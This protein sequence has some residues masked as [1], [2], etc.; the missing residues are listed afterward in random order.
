PTADVCEIAGEE[1]SFKI[2]EAI[3]VDGPT[4]DE[5]ASNAH[6]PVEPIAAVDQSIETA[7]SAR[8]VPLHDVEESVDIVE[9][10]AD[11]P[12]SENAP[13]ESIAMVA[14]EEPASESELVEAVTADEPTTE[15][16]ETVAVTEDLDTTDAVA[17][18]EPIAE[19]SETAV[20]VEERTVELAEAEEAVAEEAAADVA[21]DVVQAEPIAE[22]DGFVF[23]SE[24]AASEMGL[25]AADDDDVVL[26]DTA[27]EP[28]AETDEAV[29]EERAVDTA[30][31]VADVE[32]T[33]EIVEAAAYAEP[34]DEAD[35]VV[36]A[37][38]ER[39]A[40]VVEAVVEPVA[41]IDMAVAHEVPVI[42]ATEALAT[43]MPETVAADEL[44]VSPSR[45]DDSGERIAPVVVGTIEALDPAVATEMPDISVSAGQALNGAS[46]VE[47]FERVIETGADDATMPT[48][49]ADVDI[50]IH[51]TPRETASWNSPQSQIS[52][53]RTDSQV[54]LSVALDTSSAPVESELGQTQSGRDSAV[55]LDGDH[56]DPTFDDSPKDAASLPAEAQNGVS[57]D[58]AVP[59]PE[60]MAESSPQE[61][62]QQYSAFST[63]A[64]PE[65]FTHS[66]TPPQQTGAGGVRREIP[67]ASA[68]GS[69]VQK[70]PQSGRPKNVLMELNIETPSDGRQLL[71]LLISDDLDEVCEGFCAEHGM[72]DLLPGMKAL[73]RGK[74]ERR[75]ARRRERALQAAVAPGGRYAMQ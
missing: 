40:E 19:T 74:V 1:P 72:V 53:N 55:Y 29:A 60:H 17:E 58:Y 12:S 51:Q 49:P 47:S 7:E 70:V 44:V 35:Y 54:S 57:R 23:K 30:V 5:P 42:E 27:V 25:I 3:L 59:E 16:D 8:E 45:L 71:Q 14:T 24:V 67:R 32:Y 11:E 31:D 56:E 28:I 13:M 43:E 52:Y 61:V 20:A 37:A 18:A 6:E 2:V 38:E 34:T 21:V 26:V 39:T 46:D 33:A 48:G 50:R 75:L 65:Y 41:E 64:F 10:A 22:T 15:T 62:P 66:E 9:A 68:T 63:P 73:V 36:V 4:T 69:G